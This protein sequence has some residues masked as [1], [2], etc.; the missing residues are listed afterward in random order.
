MIDTGM[1]AQESLE[2]LSEQQQRL[3]NGKRAVQMFP[4]G[5]K[6]LSVPDGMLRTKNLRGVFHYNPNLITERRL[7]E[8]SIAGRENEFLELGPYSK[9]D[10]VKRVAGGEEP[11][12]VVEYTPDGV[13]VRAAV[14][15]T[16]T[17]NE[18]ADYFN[19]TKALFNT[20]ACAI[21]QRVKQALWSIG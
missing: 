20:V 15:C 16:S 11:T 18:Q 21:P 10:I 1:N 4:V 5:T 3:I 2:T 17:V 7:Q 9:M 19:R 13:E 12:V 14:A 8:L 6:E